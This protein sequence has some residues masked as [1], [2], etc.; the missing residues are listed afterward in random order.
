MVPVVVPDAAPVVVVVVPPAPVE[1]VVVAPPVEPGVD[2]A[3]QARMLHRV[4]AC[5]GDTPVPAHLTAALVDKYCARMQDGI[6]KYRERWLDRAMP[7]LAD[8][9]P[10]GLPTVVVYPFGGGDLMTALAT[11]PDLTEIT[12]L[13]LE[14]AGDVRAIERIDA[15]RLAPILSKNA[16]L[17]RR[18][19]AVSHSKTTNLSITTKAELPGELVFTLVALEVHGFEPVSLRYFKIEPDGALNYLEADALAAIDA[20]VAKLPDGRRKA[21]QLASFGNVEIRFRKVSDATAPL[22]TFRHI[23]GDLSDGALKKD[24]R[25]LAHLESKGRVV[26]MTKAASFLLWWDTFSLMRK[27]LLGHMEWMI[28]DATGIPNHH[29]K[30]AGFEQITW[31]RFEGPFLAGA[32]DGAPMRRVWQTNPLTPLPFRY[33]YPDS[34]GHSHMMVTRR[35]AV[36][37]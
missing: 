28:S 31:G 24:R 25:V 8:V 2:L 34:K 35:A 19:F 11:Y 37:K 18:L 20:R 27:Y 14:P 10:D 1:P 4:G 33:G 36:T 16:D 13:S 29:A 22:R 32:G 30:K 6:R 3:M 12:T 15:K 7:F 23:S 21:A 26:A 9:V 5:A 17:I